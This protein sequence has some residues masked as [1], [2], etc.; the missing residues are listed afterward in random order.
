MAE[1]AGLPVDTIAGRLWRIG[2]ATDLRDTMGMAGAAMIKERGRWASDVAFIY[3]RALVGQQMDAAAG[4]ANAQ[5]TS[6]EMAVPGWVQPA[7]LR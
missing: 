1:A 4:M 3:A 5:D 6:V 7:A 2:G